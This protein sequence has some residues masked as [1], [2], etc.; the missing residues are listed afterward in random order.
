M[1]ESRSITLDGGKSAYL[2]FVVNREEPET[3]DVYVEGVP[4]GSFIVERDLGP[5]I[6]LIISSAL[7]VAA[8]VLA[9]VY[10]WRRRQQGY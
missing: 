10:I 2:T 9:C 5:D 3:Y 7:V 6:I 4:A 8:L 1:E